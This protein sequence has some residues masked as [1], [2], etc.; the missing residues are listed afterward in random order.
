LR[1]EVP[2]FF[3]ENGAKNITAPKFKKYK[4]TPPTVDANTQALMGIPTTDSEGEGDSAGE[5][6]KRRHSTLDINELPPTRELVAFYRS[7]IGI[8]LTCPS[9]VTLPHEPLNL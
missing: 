7:R 3:F 9:S 6:P 2:F 8:F 1:G 5:S 4:T